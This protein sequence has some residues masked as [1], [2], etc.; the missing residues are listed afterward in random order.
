MFH[1]QVTEDAKALVE[2]HF[3]QTASFWQTIYENG[4]VYGLIHRKR[5]DLV[6]SFVGQL[7]LPRHAKALDIGCGAG[8]ISIGLAAQ[9]FSVHAIDPVPEMIMMTRRTAADSGLNV[10][11]QTGDILHLPF[12][13]QSFDLVLAIGVLPWLTSY[14]SALGQVRRVLRQ[15]GFFVTNIDNTLALHR[16]LD[17]GM[18]FLLRPAKKV[19][20]PVFGGGLR[21][22]SS[23]VPATTSLPGRF[24]SLL[25]N[26]G[27]ELMKHAM[28]GFGP[29]SFFGHCV[30]SQRAGVALHT[31]AQALCE[32]QVPVI[33]SLGAQYLVVAQKVSSCK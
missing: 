8:S 20:S 2:Q 18:N 32:R 25:K 9:G 4:D 31:K 7:K 17:P 12:A 5:R 6:L 21:S 28:Y 30:L 14:S 15:G 1:D 23:R 16:L 3:Q 24:R 11:A 26:S 10:V 22:R 29:I 27:F 19:L 33:R 13:P